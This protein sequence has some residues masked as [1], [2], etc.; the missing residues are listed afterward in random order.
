[1]DGIVEI[2]KSVFVIRWL[3]LHHVLVIVKELAFWLMVVLIYC[4]VVWAMLNHFNIHFSDLGAEA[5][6]INTLILGLLLG[7]RNRAAFDRWWEGRRLWGQ[8]INDCRNLANKISAYVP[9]DAVQSSPFRKLLAAY[10]L[11]LKKHLRGE[12]F[13]LDQLPGMVGEVAANPHIPMEISQR[14]F[15][16][17]SAWR[18]DGKMV[19]VQFRNIDSHINGLLIV[20]GECERIVHTPIPFSYKAMLRTGLFLHLLIAPWYTLSSLGWRGIPIL[21][22]ACFFLLGIELIDSHIEDPFGQDE[23]DLEIEQFAKTIASD[24]N[25]ALA[26]SK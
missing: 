22:L 8:L 1:M 17:V 10:P 18:K 20:C 12:Q 11:A 6:L 25:A 26:A 3:K 16:Q 24:V 19:D 4:I 15:R 9:E 5:G 13:S 21:L 23:D 2:L 7:F 14:I